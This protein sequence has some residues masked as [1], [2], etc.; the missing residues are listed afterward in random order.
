MHS[1]ESRVP[2]LTPAL[3]DFAFRLPEHL[4]VAPDGTS[5]SLLRT[6][7]RGLVPD[8]ILDRRDKIGFQTPERNWLETL[9]PWVATTLS[10]PIAQ[11]IPVFRSAALGDEFAAVMDGRL[12][13]DWRIWRWL[14]LIRWT[15]LMEV[16][17]D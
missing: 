17:F 2:F 5:K 3:V 14:N 11:D 4:L 15:E 1:I 9:R 8:A 7:L 13:F 16:R 6:A 12:P 10:S